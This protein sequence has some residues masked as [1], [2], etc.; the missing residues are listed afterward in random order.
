MDGAWHALEFETMKGGEVLDFS[1]LGN[2]AGKGA[3]EFFGRYERD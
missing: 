2:A 1:W 3:I